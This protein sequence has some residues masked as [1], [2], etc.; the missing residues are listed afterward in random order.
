MTLKTNIKKMNVIKDC[1]EWLQIA[2]PDKQFNPGLETILGWLA[3]EIKETQDGWEN[4]DTSEIED[5]CIDSNWILANMMYYYGVPLNKLS[6]KAEQ[7]RLSNLSKFCD[8]KAEAEMT[9]AAYANGIHPN[10][11]GEKIETYIQNEYPPFVI[12]RKSDGK[13]QKSIYFKEPN[14]F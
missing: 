8:T 13:I 9:V 12:R 7:V 5:G 14:K 1:Y 10:K 2:D 3:E 11:V 6:I 4:N